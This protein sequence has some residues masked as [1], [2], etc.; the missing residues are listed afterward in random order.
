[1]SGLVL[2]LPHGYEGQGPEHSSARP[3]RFLQLCAEDNI[4]VVNCSTP[5]NFYHVLRRQ[6]HR[7]FRKPLVVMTPK[8]LLRH[9]R[10]VSDLKHFGPDSSFHR[11]LYEDNLPSKPSEARQLV[12]CTGKVFYDLLEER[13]RRGITDVHILRME[14]LYPIPEDALRAEMEPYTHCELVW[15]QEEPRNMGYWFHVEQFIEEVAEE[16]GFQNPR[17]RYT[18]RHAAASPATG[19]AERHRREQ[20]ALVDDAL[21]VGKRRVGRIESRR[22]QER[23]RAGGNGAG[24]QKAA[25][26]ASGSAE[27]QSAKTAPAGKQS[28]AKPVSGKQGT[29]KQGGGKTGAKQS[30]RSSKKPE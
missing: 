13:E 8:S 4:Q 16:L 28:A 21:T 29:A 18:G 9:K 1:M 10:C 3:E 6:L 11:V 26:A 23:E 19:I 27:K 17:P 15:C 30:A 5:A 24:P 2:L 7:D 12:L 20:A 22:I 25:A 14:Q